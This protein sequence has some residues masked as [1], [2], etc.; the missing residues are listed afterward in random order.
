VLLAVGTSLLAFGALLALIAVLLPRPDE[1]R[2]GV[3]E[4]ER[5]RRN[6]EVTVVS[7]AIVALVGTTLAVSASWPWS[8]LALAAAVLV[9][10][11]ALVTATYRSN[12]WLLKEVQIA[13]DVDKRPDGK[14][15]RIWLSTA[16]YLKLAPEEWLD[17]EVAF[18]G[19]P[20]DQG[21]LNLADGAQRIAEEKARLSWALRYPM[22][23][24]QTPFDILRGHLILRRMTREARD[25]TRT[26]D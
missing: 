17:A 11:V 14:P 5:C 20:N 7:S 19:N 26:A 21:A 8:V 9:Y 2:L 4:S 18:Y 12:K 13:R 25:R 1:D 22:G 6:I 23:Q 24:G 15:G 16:V 10:Y 3:V